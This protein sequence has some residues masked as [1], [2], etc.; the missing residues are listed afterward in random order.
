[1]AVPPCGDSQL[2]TIIYGIPDF[3]TGCLWQA[4]ERGEILLAGND[5]GED[6]PLWQCVNCNTHLY[7]VLF[8]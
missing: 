5:T 7:S 3:E 2:A 6:Y 4:L 8:P 1:M